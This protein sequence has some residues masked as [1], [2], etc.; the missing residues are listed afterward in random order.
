[1][2]SVLT[3]IVSFARSLLSN[4]P[5]KIVNK[6][7]YAKVYF[8]VVFIKLMTQNVPLFSGDTFCLINARFFT[9]NY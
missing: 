3:K 7:L 1:M 5:T 6:Y 9:A 4:S 8:L 2:D